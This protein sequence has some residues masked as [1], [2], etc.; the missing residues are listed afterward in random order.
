MN[1]PKKIFHYFIYLNLSIGFLT[2]LYMVFVVYKIPGQSGPLFA[3][4]LDVP[5][6]FFLQRRLYALEAWLCFIGLALY[7]AMTN[8]KEK[9]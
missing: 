4:A 5:H 1:K 6:E 9:T 3:K 2:A 8:T 7:F